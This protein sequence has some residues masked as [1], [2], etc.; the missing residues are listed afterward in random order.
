V[1]ELRRVP[2][3]LAATVDACLAAAPG[4][5]PAVGEVADALDGLIGD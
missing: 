4:D 1:A 5:R 2:A 3:P